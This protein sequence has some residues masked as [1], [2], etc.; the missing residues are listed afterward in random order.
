MDWHRRFSAKTLKSWGV[1]QLKCCVCAAG[2]WSPS[3]SGVVSRCPQ[4]LI[5]FTTMLPSGARW[6]GSLRLVSTRLWHRWID[7][8]WRCCLIRAASLTGLWID[9]VA[10]IV[11][12]GALASRLTPP[13]QKKAP[14]A[15]SADACGWRFWSAGCD[16]D[17][18]AGHDLQRPACLPSLSFPAARLFANSGKVASRL[19]LSGRM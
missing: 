17:A 1:M 19:S 14:I 9:S 10:L 16:A 18:D 2:S 6:L 13:L 5:G 8:V 3:M 7:V 11:R 12:Q 15:P 4:S